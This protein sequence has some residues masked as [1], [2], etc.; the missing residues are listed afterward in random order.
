[1]ARA[2]PDRGPGTSA[3]APKTTAAPEATA[4]F[5]PGHKGRCQ[6]GTAVVPARSARRRQ[7]CGSSSPRPCGTGWSYRRRRR[8]QR[9]A[10]APVPGWPP[11]LA[12]RSRS[13]RGRQPVP[14]A[15]RPPS[16]LQAGG[17]SR[18]GLAAG[19]HRRLAGGGHRRL[20]PGGRAARTRGT[21]ARLTRSLRSGGVAGLR[22]SYRRRRTARTRWHTAGQSKTARIA[23]NSQLA[24]H[25][26]RWCRC[27]VRTSVG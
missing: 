9:S 18:A 10:R 4:R 21:L 2:G 6:S 24:G 25:F 16:R 8:Q 1:M 3:G 5:P 20:R 15:E 17:R 13:P 12:V 11:P 7:A 23:E 22:R 26:R 19:H 14:G 27:W